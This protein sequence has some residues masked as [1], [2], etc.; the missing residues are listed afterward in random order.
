MTKRL[1]PVSPE[2]RARAVADGAG[3]SRRA[4]R[5]AADPMS[6][7][8]SGVAIGQDNWEFYVDAL[9]LAHDDYER[10]V[11]DRVHLKT[12]RLRTTQECN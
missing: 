12:R 10:F 7:R 1:P 4:P 6:Q 11:R 5:F 9:G 2:V 8:N 3:P